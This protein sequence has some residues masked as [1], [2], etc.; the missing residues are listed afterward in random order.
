[1]ATKLLKQA[2]KSV[3]GL[4]EFKRKRDQFSRDLAFFDENRDKLLEDY[5]QRWVAVYESE[6]VAHSKHYNNVISQLERSD[7]PVEQLVIRFISAHKVMALYPK[8]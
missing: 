8:Q 1:M 7:L 5:K 6:I 3:G 2:L 4:E